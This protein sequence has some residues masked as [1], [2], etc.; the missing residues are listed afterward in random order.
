MATQTRTT[1]QPRCPSVAADGATPCGYP[2]GHHDI[3]I[4]DIPWEHG[5]PNLGRWWD[6]HTSA[7]AE[8]ILDEDLEILSMAGRILGSLQGRLEVAITT[9]N[10][11]YRNGLH[12]ELQPAAEQPAEPATDEPDT[13]R[14]H[15]SDY[16]G[17]LT[18][19]ATP[20]WLATA[21][22]TGDL[23]P[24]L[25]GEDYWYLEIRT[26]AGVVTAEP[27]DTILKHCDGSLLVRSPDGLCK[28]PTNA[29]DD[30]PGQEGAEAEED[31][32]FIERPK[33]AQGGIMSAPGPASPI[34]ITSPQPDPEAFRRLL[35][36]EMA[37]RGGRGAA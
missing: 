13:V 32:A 11:S 12:D 30:E 14:F 33:R 4:E 17:A 5:N 18:F 20:T 35:R 7:T 15:A 10:T 6:N 26:P 19:S 16:H 29:T 2:A 8:E 36:E 31:P 28:K 24:I 34:V 22:E 25:K 37:R 23:K 21:L 27:G 1:D 9:F 3:M